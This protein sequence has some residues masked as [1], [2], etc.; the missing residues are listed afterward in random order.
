MTT[1]TESETDVTTETAQAGPVLAGVTHREGIREPVTGDQ[2]VIGEIIVTRHDHTTVYRWI[3]ATPY[4][5][6]LTVDGLQRALA[7]TADYLGGMSDADRAALKG[8]AGAPYFRVSPGL[9]EL[10]VILGHADQVVAMM[11]EVINAEG[12]VGTF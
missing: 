6:A 11:T 10:P 8:V 2:P 9:W 3:C 7:A 1:K 4:V 5:V 12:S